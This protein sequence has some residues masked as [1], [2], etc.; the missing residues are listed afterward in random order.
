MSAEQSTAGEAELDTAL[1]R[2]N[3]LAR[4][5]DPQLPER[6]GL[7]GPGAAD[8]LLVV[9]DGRI[10]AV[11]VCAVETLEPGH[12]EALW[13]S[14]RSAEL[15]M[16]WDGD[17]GPVGELLERW[18]ERTAAELG[19]PGDWESSLWLRAPSRDSA[20]VRPLLAHGF[21]LVDITAIRVGARGSDAQQALERLAAAGVQLR[22][23]VLEDAGLLGEM[24][25][26]LLAHDAQ[27]GGVELREGAAQVLQAG[28][29]ERLR[30]DPGWTWVVERGGAPVGYLSIEI[31]RDRH[32]EKCAPGGRVA[33]VQAMY[34]RPVV[35]GDGIG[36]AVVEFG[37]G[38]LEREGFD[39]VL[40]SY[41]AL[42]P[43][44]GP[45][46]CRMGYRPLWGVWQRR[47][48]RQRV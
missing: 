8:P 2:M 41:A 18:I 25:A 43:R 29:E 33:F 7:G 9:R 44:S 19:D 10:G 31:D 45:F 14:Y 32:R 46:W 4:G 5:L 16:G 40:L 38:L 36:E 12:P 35:R 39:R 22:P 6:I 23:A 27:H 28:I 11:G 34:L 30:A 1:Q 13:G 15:R 47:P 26:E 21:A 42:N 37:H 20:L 3:A 24:D 17:E 48:A